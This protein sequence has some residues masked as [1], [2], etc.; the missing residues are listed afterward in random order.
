MT[1]TPAPPA[2]RSLWALRDYRAWLLADTAWQF[3]SS[4]RTFAMT[5]VAYS[6][7]GSYAQA[8][9]VAT[10]STL[11]GAV[12]ILPGGVL[13]DR[14]D[15][16]TS[17]V[18]SG[19][20]R[21]LVFAAT[22]LAWWAGVLNLP[23]L[24][25][26]G[27]LTGAL[28]GL[29]ASASNAALKSVVPGED[30]PRAIAANQARDAAVTLSAPPLSGLLMGVSYALPFAAAAVGAAL[31]ALATRLIRADLSP[32][33][34]DR[35]TGRG[36]AAGTERG[37]RAGTERD[38]GSPESESSEVLRTRSVRSAVARTLVDMVSGFRIFSR[39]RMLLH[40]V[41]AIV[42]INMGFS[43]LYTGLA[44]QLQGQGVEAWRIGIIDSAVAGGML[45]GALVASPLI[46]RF[47]TGK[48]TLVLFLMAA[49]FMVP[50]ALL[51]VQV[52]ILTCFA[53]V[54]LLL[55][56]LNGGIVGY[57]QAMIPRA[58]QGR[59]MSALAMANELGV[60]TVPMAVGAGLQWWGGAP[61][62]MS[63]IAVFLLAS[64]LIATNRELRAL[65]TPDR[66]DL[67]ED[68]ATPPP[69]QS[70]GQLPQGTPEQA[71]PG[72]DAAGGDDLAQGG[73]RASSSAA[74]S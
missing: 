18:L 15:R 37:G 62:M 68:S 38:G 43:A 52:V 71:V 42:C 7:T 30:L 33:G 9:L 1:P 36:G 50:V 46:A 14:I 8:G 63:T 72:V 59:T 22:A 44:L 31:Q 34:G 67:P 61:T 70:G 4:I 58:E 6:V 13:V 21:S 24:L 74:T 28:S 32:H 40:L 2:R 65:P 3:G 73:L 20:L 56:A 41:P 53:L 25:A 57:M 54:G 60:A 35:G 11:A 45:V 23:A 26:S 27:V 19:I 66:W 5:L 16:R 69:P 29:F 17:L 49:V 48:L 10:A 47:P 12:T 39:S 64:V 55:P 51:P